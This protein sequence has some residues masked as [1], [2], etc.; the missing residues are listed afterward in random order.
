LT[1]DA[2]FVDASSIQPRAGWTRP[3]HADRHARSMHVGVMSMFV[4]CGVCRGQRERA[5]ERQCRRK[6]NGLIFHGRFLQVERVKRA[7]EPLV[8]DL[9]GLKNKLELLR[10]MH[11]APIEMM[12]LSKAAL[13]KL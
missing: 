12:P 1:T 9:A 8:R 4:G 13:G 10:R 6:N 2:R 11:D 7:A 3:R 5:T